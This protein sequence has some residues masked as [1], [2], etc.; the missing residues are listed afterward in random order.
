[1]HLLCEEM[2]L[3]WWFKKSSATADENKTLNQP[4]K[5]WKQQKEKKEGHVTSENCC[6]S[7]DTLMTLEL[8]WVTVLLSIVKKWLQR[9]QGR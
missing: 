2:S 5:W 3:K 4:L 9:F 7:N 8:R 6:N 1:M